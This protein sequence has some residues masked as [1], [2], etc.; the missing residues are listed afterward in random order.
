M[1]LTPSPVVAITAFAASTSWP[2]ARRMRVLAG[3]CQPVGRG[4]RTAALHPWHLA[5]RSKSRELA[6]A[7]E[8]AVRRRYHEQMWCLTVATNA[9]VAWTTE[10]YGLAVTALRWAGRSIDD[11]LLTHI[12]LSHHANVNFY[13]THTVDI[14]GEPAKLDA[15]GYLPLRLP[16]QG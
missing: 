5:L 14:D 1:I 16:A 15:D 2:R 3:P 7:S 4:R 8:G 11:D 10:Y 13:G 6:Y 12:W 9:I